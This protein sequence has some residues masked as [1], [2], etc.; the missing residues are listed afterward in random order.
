[1]QNALLHYIHTHTV[2]ERRQINVRKWRCAL[3]TCLAL[4]ASV[5]V[6][7]SLT[8]YP[9]LLIRQKR[10]VQFSYQCW[11]SSIPHLQ[12]SGKAVM[13][14]TT[15]MNITTTVHMS[16]L[17]PHFTS[18]T[19]GV[20]TQLYPAVKRNCTELMAGD[21]AEIAHVADV[22]SS[23]KGA[24]NTSVLGNVSNC[25]QIEEEFNNNFYVSSDEKTFPIA[26]ILI[27]YTNPQQIVRFLKAVYRP[28]NLYCIHPDIRSGQNF[29]S[30]F[31]FLSKCLPN[32]FIASHIQEVH[33]ARSSIFKAQ[34]SCYRD[35]DKYPAD[36][37]HYVINLCGRELPLKTNLEIVENLRAMNGTSIIRPQLVDNHTLHERFYKKQRIEV[38][39][40]N[41]THCNPLYMNKTLEKPPFGITLYKSLSYNALSRAFVRYFLHNETVQTFMQWIEHAWVPEEHFYASVYMM[42]GSPGG[43]S[44]LHPIKSQALVSKVIWKHN[45]HSPY[46]SPSERC[47]GRSVH[48]ICI[49]TSAELPRVKDALKRNMWFFNKYFMEDDHVIM[50]CVEEVL[51]EKNMEEFHQDNQ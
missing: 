36:K 47:A 12:S 50:D 51:V 1:M 39:Y 21:E 46:Y 16:L 5:L 40:G 22:M 24:N 19:K 6:Y 29:S 35:L 2:Q 14:D 32:I 33:Y 7:T 26:Y 30:V 8:N 4:S 43:H 15:L 23:W 49:L 44:S 34:L 27:V 10:P 37:W 31:H 42:P 20:I 25:S 9:A 3:Q 41:I 48:Q 11:N 17:H 38:N 28:Q 18:W 45:Q 13:N